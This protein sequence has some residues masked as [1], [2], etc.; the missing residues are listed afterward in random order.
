M[1]SLTCLLT[2]VVAPLT[3]YILKERRKKVKGR[4]YALEVSFGG[5]ICF[6]VLFYYK[7]TDLWQIKV[8]LGI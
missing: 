8:K 1:D 7:V 5:R 3:T 2:W 6:Y 4:T